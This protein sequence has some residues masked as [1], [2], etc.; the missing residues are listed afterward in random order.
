MKKLT[1]LKSARA[2]CLWCCFDSQ[3]E[4]RLC[5]VETCPLWK[6]RLGKGRITLK[7]LRSKCKDCDPEGYKSIKNCPFDG[8]SDILC[9]LHPYRLGRRPKSRSLQGKT[10]VE[11]K[12]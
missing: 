3:L 1:P 10:A 2:F 7:I 12:F 5:P 9:P 6:Y 11:L 4:V 8:V